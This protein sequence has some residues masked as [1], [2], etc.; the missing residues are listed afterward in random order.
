MAGD[1]DAETDD[2]RLSGRDRST[3]NDLSIAVRDGNRP[4]RCDDDSC[5][6]RAHYRTGRFAGDDLVPGSVGM[7]C[8]KCASDRLNVSKD[9]L[10]NHR[11]GGNKGALGI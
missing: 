3:A 5:K 2:H 6:E 10:P 4:R 11:R 7:Y 9:A 1:P 8:K